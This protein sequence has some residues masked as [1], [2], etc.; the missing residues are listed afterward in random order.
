MITPRPISQAN[1]ALA[2]RAVRAGVLLAC[3]SALLAVS[4]GDVRGYASIRVP[5]GPSGQGL[6]VRWDLNNVA[7][8]PNIANRRVR[9][10]IADKGCADAKN[11]LGPINEFQAVQDAFSRWR[12][13]AESDIDFEFAG[14]TTNAVTSASDNRNVVR[15]VNSNI[16]TGVF[17][18]TITTFDTTTGQIVDADLELNDRDFTWDTLGPNG[19]QGVI[20]RAMIEN[21]VTHEI[22]HFIGLDHSQVAHGAMYFASAPGI[23]R[24]TVIDPDSRAPVIRDYTNADVTDPS[25][26]IV[27]GL[28]TTGGGP[29]FGAEVLLLNYSTGRVIIGSIS[30]GS[31]GPFAAG[32]Y[33]IVNV[34][35]GVYMALAVPVNKSNL[36]SY[37]GSA[38]TSFYPVLRGITAGSTGAPSLVRVGPGQTVTGIDIALPATVNPFEPDNSSANATALTSGHAAVSSISP[39]TDEDW[40]SFT[41]T[42]A[43]QSATIR[44][45]ADGF[46]SGLNPTLTVYGTN[47]STVLVSPT[48]G[49]AAYVPSANDIDELAFDLSGPNFDAEVTRAFATPGTYFF[50]VASRAVATT[51]RYVVLLELEG[52]DTTPDP[53]ASIIESSV[54]GIAAGG[55]GNFTVTVTPRN[56]FGR[57]LNAPGT[58]TVELLDVTTGSPVVL[59]TITGGTTP[60]A[61]TESALGTAQLKRYSARIDSVPIAAGVQVSHYG[62][63]SLTNSRMIPMQKTLSANGYDKTL[64]RIEL[65]DGGNNRLADSTVAVTVDTSRGTL[66]SGTLSGT[67]GVAAAFD[68]DTGYWWITL[69]AGSTTGAANLVAYA[70]SQQIDTATVNIL[71]RANGTGGGGTTTDDKKKEDDD[72]GCT[73][74]RGGSVFVLGLLLLFARRRRFSAG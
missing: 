5:A 70:N 34:P 60:F 10:E 37:Y 69:T 57:D 32:S 27:Q 47:G 61:F 59:Q 44:V 16:S 42:T 35:P 30:E 53:A 62:T 4:G 38:F 45:I 58:F 1:P 71:A 51:G 18:V 21:V 64:V 24:Q 48:F 9:Y 54:P 56:A 67:T 49:H 63:L 74:S 25:L 39:A 15:W 26:G 43:G 8:R 31:A 2:G 46:G 33:E 6:P 3:V 41:T 29:A 20:G 13:V 23:I 7:N 68:A 11:F 36:G 28:V 22:G 52:A 66:S 72:G 55:G 19:T 12:A 40:Y 50:K 73:I 17:A 65:R 14:A